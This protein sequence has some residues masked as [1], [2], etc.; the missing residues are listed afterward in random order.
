MDDDG[1]QSN[2]P[3]TFRYDRRTTHADYSQ[4]SIPDWG[5]YLLFL[6]A[7]FE[8]FLSF[9]SFCETLT[10]SNCRY[11]TVFDLRLLLA[12]LVPLRVSFFTIGW[13]DG[14]FCLVTCLD[15]Q[16]LCFQP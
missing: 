3:D 10:A 12:V 4:Y 15:F 9:C 14:S 6:V 5:F 16:Y 13:M 11:R 1:V 2:G 8:W 7:N